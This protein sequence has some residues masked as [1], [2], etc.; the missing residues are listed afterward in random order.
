MSVTESLLR[1]KPGEL[2]LPIAQEYPSA[3]IS[4]NE[5]CSK[6]PLKASYSSKP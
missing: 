2:P 1:R 6:S 5:A 3:K 4:C